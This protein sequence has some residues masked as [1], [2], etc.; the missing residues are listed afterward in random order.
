MRKKKKAPEEK[1]RLSS[2]VQINPIT[3]NSINNIQNNNTVQ[4][5]ELYTSRIKFIIRLKG[6]RIIYKRLFH[7]EVKRLS[8]CSVDGCDGNGDGGGGVT[9]IG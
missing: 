6:N 7:A 8:C 9:C 4:L 3:I 2:Y 1:K 5:I